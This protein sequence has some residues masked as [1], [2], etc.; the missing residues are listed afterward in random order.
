MLHEYKHLKQ[1]EDDPLVR[2]DAGSDTEMYYLGLEME[3]YHVGAR[4]VA[5]V[6]NAG[7]T[8]VDSGPQVE[9]DEMRI[10]WN[11][12]GNFDPSAGLRQRLADAG[13]AVRDQ[14]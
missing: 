8:V 10:A 11:G 12:D 4:A 2:T 3:A 13:L 5:G 14:R 9:R 1:F 6:R 7:V